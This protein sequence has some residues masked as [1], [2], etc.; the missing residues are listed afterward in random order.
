[1]DPFLFIVGRGRSG[2]TLLR[3]MFDS[4]PAMVIPPESHFIV[5]LGRKRL[6]YERPAGFDISRFLGDVRRTNFQRWGLPVEAARAAL[7]S[8]RPST[9]PEAVRVLFAANAARQGKWRY[10]EKTP[11]NVRNITYLANLFPE[12]SFVHIVRDGRD[13][14]LSYLRVDFGVDS[15]AE[16]AMY[17]KLAVEK[18][19]RAGARLGP[20]R[21]REI[22][23]EDLVRT[24]EPVL[25]GL[26]SFLDLPFDPR[27]LRYHERAHSVMKGTNVAAH[28]N[29]GRPPMKLR[30]WRQ[31]MR[32]E[33]VRLFESLAGRTLEAF[34]YERAVRQI[35]FRTQLRAPLIRTAFHARRARS[36]VK[37]AIQR[38]R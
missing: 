1:M 12:A 38:A 33:D 24:P 8:A 20:G 4:H 16:S 36:R 34:G 14:T 21:Y 35:P 11:N 5:H 31:E 37:K 32:A 30:D 25:Q 6:R 28:D 10:G 15:V 9:F 3:A 2:T 29:I 22:R 13:V 27:M 19:R 17:W 18:G 23:Y 7:L 26:C